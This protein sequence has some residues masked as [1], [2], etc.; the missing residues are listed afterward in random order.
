M[1]LQQL[2][3]QWRLLF[4]VVLLWMLFQ[5]I[6]VFKGIENSPFI[7]YYMFSTPHR[8]MDSIPVTL[9]KTP[10]GYLDQ[11]AFTNREA[12]LLLNNVE[13]Y[14]RMRK[15]NYQDDILPTIAHRLPKNWSSS[16]KQYVYTSLSNDSVHFKQYPNWWF[17]YAGSIGVATQEP[18]EMVRS[19]VYF[20]NGQLRK[21]LFDSVIFKTTMR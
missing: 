9:I 11:F 5:L 12:E 4:W 3:R 20:D 14:N 21:S 7:L 19:Y 8:A 6:S 16:T 13:F 17:R 2:Y 18:I 15:N 1:F 10:T